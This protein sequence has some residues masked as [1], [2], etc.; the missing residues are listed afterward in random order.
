MA[1]VI[2]HYPVNIRLILQTTFAIT[3]YVTLL[4]KK[5]NN[6]IITSQIKILK[7]IYDHIKTHLSYL[8]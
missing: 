7:K 1:Y 4:T 3:I 6:I 2:Y 8:D 5:K